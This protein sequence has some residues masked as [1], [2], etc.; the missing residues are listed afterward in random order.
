MMNTGRLIE[1][2]PPTGIEQGLTAQEAKSEIL[3]VYFH[4]GPRQLSDASATFLGVR[5]RNTNYVP[6]L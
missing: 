4:Q 2:A 1:I 5:W 6:Y 3:K